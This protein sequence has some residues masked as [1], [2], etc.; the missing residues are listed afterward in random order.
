MLDNNIVTL[1]EKA[2]KRIAD[3][4]ALEDK[5]YRFRIAIAGGGCS[6]FTYHF[7]FDESKADDDYI[8]HNDQYNVEIIVDPMSLMYLIGAQVDFEQ[9]LSGN[10]FVVNNPSASSTC[11]CGQSFS[12]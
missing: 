5:P 3:L 6:G 11:G 8:S 9:G 10:K 2:A 1:T 12:I 7:T 4:I